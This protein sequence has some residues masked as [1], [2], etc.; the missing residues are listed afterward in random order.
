MQREDV[1]CFHKWIAD[2]EVIEFS[3][4]VFQAMTTPQQIDSWF[5]ATLQDA[6]S[7]SLG[8]YTTDTN[9]L[10]GYAGLS[11]I[12]TVNQ[13]GEYFILIGEKAF[14]GKGIGTAVTKEVVAI[15]FTKLGLNRIMLTVSE[16]NTGGLKAYARAGFTV[17]G[18][19]REACLRHG[20]F[21]DKIMMSV[22][23]SEWQH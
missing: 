2:P 23:K 19:M 22:L 12:S 9:E 10:I 8:I 5:A 20:S 17:E 21:H 6:K 4:S 1:A 7:L 13:S 16:T 18:R 3:L 14:W 15:G 11:G